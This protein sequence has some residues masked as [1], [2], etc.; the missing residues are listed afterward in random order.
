MAAAP[1]QISLGQHPPAKPAR[2]GGRKVFGDL[3]S[4]LWEGEVFKRQMWFK[5]IS[6]MRNAALGRHKSL[7]SPKN[8]SGSG[9]LSFPPQLPLGSTEWA[10]WRRPGEQ[11]WSAQ[12]PGPR[13]AAGSS[14][15][16]TKGQ[17]SKAGARWLSRGCPPRNPDPASLPKLLLAGS[18]Q[19]LSGAASKA[20]PVPGQM[21]PHGRPWWVNMSPGRVGRTA[22]RC[23]L[24]PHG[25]GEPLAAS[26]PDWHFHGLPRLPGR[27]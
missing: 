11:G 13:W 19:G 16:G 17:T 1:Q 6:L 3:K 10:S 4:F 14:P 12:R 7:N 26:D 23:H 21:P 24:H 27:P 15:P 9:H 2:R 22:P 5:V 25:R 8:A 20:V 18:S